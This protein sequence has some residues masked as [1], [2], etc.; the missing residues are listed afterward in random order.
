MSKNTS[1]N[2][3]SMIIGFRVPKEY[4][5][6]LDSYLMT[7][8]QKGGQWLIQCIEKS[9][10]TS[11]SQK[12]LL[13]SVA[14]VKDAMFFLKSYTMLDRDKV[15]A[16]RVFHSLDTLDKQLTDILVNFGSH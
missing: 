5:S 4:K 9:V 8:G 2:N 12:E 14:D 7:T 15:R 10:N 3:Y 6:I 16:K 1:T 11:R 13:K